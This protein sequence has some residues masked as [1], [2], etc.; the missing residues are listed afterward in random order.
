MC[1]KDFIEKIRQVGSYDAM[2]LISKYVVKNAED[3]GLSMSDPLIR[4]FVVPQIGIECHQ[5]YT[6]YRRVYPN[7]CDLP[8]TELTSDIKSCI[9]QKCIEHRKTHKITA[10]PNR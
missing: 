4:D 2:A 9:D 7:I 6:G 1:D 10:Q 5:I 8:A 3:N